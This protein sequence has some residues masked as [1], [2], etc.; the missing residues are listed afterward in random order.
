MISTFNCKNTSEITSKNKVLRHT[1]VGTFNT[2]YYNENPL[3]TTTSVQGVEV[4]TQK[5]CPIIKFES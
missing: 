4:K 1:P 3:Q 5:V 2:E